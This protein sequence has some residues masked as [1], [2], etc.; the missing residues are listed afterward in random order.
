M[1]AYHPI[2]RP[3]N[4][5]DHPSSGACAKSSVQEERGAAAWSKPLTSLAL[6]LLE[7]FC[8]EKEERPVFATSP[9]LCH[10][11]PTCTVLIKYKIVPSTDIAHPR[12][13]QTAE[14][15][16]GYSAGNLKELI[17]LSLAHWVNS[18]RHAVWLV[19]KQP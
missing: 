14:A 17:F 19:L 5:R 9:E 15:T 1:G 12:S 18:Q 10:S 7:H 3:V 4:A 13:P 2:E 6:G 16:A 11:L 8:I